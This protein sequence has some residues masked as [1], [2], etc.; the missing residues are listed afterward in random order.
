MT[1]GEPRGSFSSEEVKIARKLFGQDVLFGNQAGKSSQRL[2]SL[3]PA[4]SEGKTVRIIDGRRYIV[5]DAAR[6]DI[7]NPHN[8]RAER[9]R[10]NRAGIN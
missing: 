9:D 8:K 7:F 3:E 4:E 1:E 2:P 6:D 5:R 10:L